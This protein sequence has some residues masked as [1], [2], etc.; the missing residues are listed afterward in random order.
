MLLDDSTQLAER[1]RQ[2]G[3]NVTL[4]I[5]EGMWHV[6]QFAAASIP[7]FPEGKVA[8]ERIGAFVQQQVSAADVAQESEQQSGDKTVG[9]T[10]T[11]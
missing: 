2:A 3:V 11:G 10:A 5:G 6:W 1:A 4:F 9:T 8:L 7:L